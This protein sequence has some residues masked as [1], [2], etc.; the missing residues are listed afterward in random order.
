MTTTSGSQGPRIITSTLSLGAFSVF[1]M[2]LGLAGTVIITRHFS[3]DDFGAYILVT[4]LASFLSQISTFGFELAVTKFIAGA[5][6]KFRQEQFFSTAVIVRLGAILLTSL[7]AWYGSPVLKMLFGQSLLPGFFFY[8]PL[9]FAIDSFK[10]ILKATLQGCLLFQKIGI[11]NAVESLTFFILLVVVYWINGDITLLFLARITSSCLAS[12]FA[13]V[14]IPITKRIAFQRDAFN[15]LMKFGF[16]LQINDIMAFIYSRI[17][18]V[19]VAMFLG[20]ADIA[21]YEV[22]RK[23]PEYLRNF[24]EPFRSVYYPFISKRYAQDGKQKASEFVNDAVR[25]VA[26]V[27]LLGAAIATLFGHEILQFVFSDKYSSSA[28]VFVV[29]MLNLSI[30]LISN[31]MGTTLVAVGDTQKPALINFFNAIASWLGSILLIPLFALLGASIANT[32]GTAIAMPL[33]RYFLQKRI[34]LKDATYLKPMLLFGVWGMLVFFIKPETLLL[35][36]VF[37]FVFVLACALLSIITKKDLAILVDG[38]RLNSWP[39]FQKLSMWISR[40]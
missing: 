22:A 24:Y 34:D 1:S 12:I 31:V 18:S 21:M 17:D 15:D 14:Y 35:K 23:I 19:A 10:S 6:D 3:A 36:I 5:V 8:V 25:F 26:F 39:P 38:L 28:P 16:P 13:F 4:I 7:L 20:P 11:V 27:T 30:G 33:N 40:L 2:V 37:L 9:L 29:L 32:T